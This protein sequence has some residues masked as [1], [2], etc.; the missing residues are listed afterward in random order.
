MMLRKFETIALFALCTTAAQGSSIL[1]SV[2]K[3]PTGEPALEAGQFVAESWTQTNTWT[4]VSVA[5]FVNTASAADQGATAYLTTQIGPGATSA[6][7]VTQDNLTLPVGLSAPELQ[8]FSGL[9]LGPGTYY[10]ILA[11]T[12]TTFNEGWFNGN[13]SSVTGLGVTSNGP[14]GLFANV[15]LNAAYPPASTFSGHYGVGYA[16]DVTGTPST[17]PEPKAVTLLVALLILGAS[18][19]KRLA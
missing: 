6:T 16:F 3:G 12:D 17:V 5:A 2:P 7:L 8:L 19:R 11:S 15:T 9:T 13:G 4:G 14:P 1:V 10:L 18:Y